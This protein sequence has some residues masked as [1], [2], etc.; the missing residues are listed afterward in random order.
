M[1]F[2]SKQV[3]YDAKLYYNSKKKSFNIKI[4]AKNA[5]FTKKSF[6]KLA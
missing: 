4:C 2:Y 5:K 1:N 6:F 3:C